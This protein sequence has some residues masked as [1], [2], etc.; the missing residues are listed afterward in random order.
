MGE[1]AGAARGGLLSVVVVSIGQGGSPLHRADLLPR[2]GGGE[3]HAE[4]GRHHRDVEALHTFLHHFVLHILLVFL[5]RS[6]SRAV[7][8]R[9]PLPHRRAGVQRSVLRPGWGR[10]WLLGHLYPHCEGRGRISVDAHIAGLQAVLS[11]AIVV[12][13]FSREVSVQNAPPSLLDVITRLEHGEIAGI[14]GRGC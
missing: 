6:N 2:E 1:G 3:V 10:A 11:T 12:N 7:C 13:A 4:A 9:P 5:H 14:T 8:L